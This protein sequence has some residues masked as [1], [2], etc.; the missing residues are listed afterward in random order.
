MRAVLAHTDLD[1]ALDKFRNKESTAWTAEEKRKDLL[2]EKTT[3]ALWLKL[4]SI[5]MSKD[6]TSKMHMKMK[7]YTHKL[8]EGGSVL[9]Y[10]LVFKEIVADLQ[11][12]EV[13][14]DDEDLALILLCSLPS[15]FANFRDTLLYSHDIL[16]VNE[17]YEA[18][19]A[20]E[21]MK[22]MVSTDGSSSNEDALFVR[23]RTKKKSNNGH[24]GKSSNGYRD[25]SKSRSKEKF[26]KYCKM[27][28]HDIPECYKLQNKENRRGTYKPK[29]KSNAEGKAFVASTNSSSESEVLI[30]FARCAVKM[31]D[32]WVLDSAASYHICIHKD[33][34]T[35]YQPTHSG[36]SVLMGD[37]RPRKI[38]GIGSIQ[39]KMH[40]GMVRT[41]TDVR[42]V[43]TMTILSL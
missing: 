9:N 37:D 38:E 2:E 12:M 26:C 18:L 4:Q 11:A 43:T 31:E 34:F 8:Q 1:E 40:D 16:S 39:I 33:W 21:K 28:N 25:R 14:Y 30:A 15:S 17:I 10:L 42:H 41:L 27:D 35:T 29:G 3:A 19:H 32:Q 22:Q 6:L 7:L 20:K 23:G 13:K 36:G 24:R 5:C